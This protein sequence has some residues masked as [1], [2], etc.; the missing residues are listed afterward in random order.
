[1]AALILI[2]VD[3]TVC[4]SARPTHGFTDWEAVDVPG[5]GQYWVSLTLL[6]RLS[7]LAKIPGV[8][9]AWFSDWDVDAKH[10]LDLPVIESAQDDSGP[11]GWWKLKELASIAAGQELNLL[12]WADD[13]LANADGSTSHLRSTAQSI[14]DAA[15]MKSVFIAPE[16]SLGLIPENLRLMEVLA[17][18]H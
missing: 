5:R 7:L 6:N 14:V 1:M 16:P 9:V 11:I 17:L 10:L 8:V 2:D 15:S 13:F 12:M 4:P 18:S 3:G